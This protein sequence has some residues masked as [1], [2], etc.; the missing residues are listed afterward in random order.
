MV[1]EKR[2]VIA[3]VEYCVLILVLMEHGLGVFAF[4]AMGLTLGLNP[5]SNGTWSR[6]KWITIKSCNGKFV[7]ILVLMEHGLGD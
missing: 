3:V 7:L 6:R 1:S 2:N 4:M 5:C